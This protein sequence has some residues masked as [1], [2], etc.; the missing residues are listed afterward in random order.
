MQDFARAVI[1][2][3]AETAGL[4]EGRVIDQVKKDNL[5]IDR[6]RLELQFLPERYTR[7]GRKLAVT[8]GK[9]EQTRKRELYEVELTVGANVLAEDREWLESFSTAFVAALPRGENDDLGNWVRIRAQKATFGRPPDK[10]VGDSVIE[11]F[12]RVNRLFLLT[13]V[14]RITGEEREELIPSFTINPTFKG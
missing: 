1:T 9:T 11:V 2:R 7:T 14:S 12:T 8:R 13:F 10:R 3:A 4:P 5:T 6:P